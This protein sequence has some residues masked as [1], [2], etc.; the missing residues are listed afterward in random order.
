MDAPNPITGLAEFDKHLDDLFQ[1]VTTNTHNLT[2]TPKL[3]DDVELQLTETNIPPLIPLFLPKLTTLLQSYTKGD[4]APIVTLTIKLLGPIPFTQ[5][6]QLASEESLITALGSPSPQVN[7]L[8]L[9]IL[10]KAASSPGDAAILSVMPSLFS[11]LIT[12]WLASPQVE[13]AQKGLK[14]LGDLLDVDC[15]LPPPPP[16]PPI[17]SG[18]TPT[19]SELVLHKAPGKGLLWNLL[20]NSEE[21]YSLLLDLISG[22]HPATAAGN[23]HQLSLAQGRALRILPR[24]AC[25]NLEGISRSGLGVIPALPVRVPNG[26]HSVEGEEEE[27][28]K[29]EE[30]EVS[31][32]TP[33]EGLLQFAALHMIDKQDVLMHLSLVDFFEAFVSLMRLTEYSAY[34]VE[35]TKRLLREALRNDEVLKEALVTLPDRTVEEEAEGLRRW[36]VEVLP[37]GVVR[38]VVIR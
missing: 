32:P 3:F 33:G 35:V 9:T 1:D 37:E 29:K 22:R 17:S 23:S 16:P 27:E 14:V 31:R 20:F 28:E 11:A 8:A 6:L 18:I 26:H 19:Y 36:L 4:P 34:K 12:T 2:L 5:I 38:D 24:L 13:V 21:V 7:L 10:H 30:P 25:L 15:P